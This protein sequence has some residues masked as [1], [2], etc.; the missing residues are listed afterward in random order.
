[1]PDAPGDA[2]RTVRLAVFVLDTNVVLDI[3]SIHDVAQ[4]VPAQNQTTLDHAFRRRRARAALLLGCY[5]HEQQIQTVSIR[6]AVD[7]LLDRVPP[8]E[9]FE[10]Y[11]VTS[12]WSF[13][14]PQ[15]LSG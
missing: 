4:T 11:F 10:S 2:T 14:R 7:K 1:M 12:F 6:E 13:L 15:V 9:S 8:G 5:C 3:V